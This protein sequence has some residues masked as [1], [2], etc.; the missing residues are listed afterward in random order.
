[1]FIP[2]VIQFWEA[3][4]S[5][6]YFNFDLWRRLAW[7][8]SFPYLTKQMENLPVGMDEFVDILAYSRRFRG[9]VCM[10]CIYIYCSLLIKITANRLYLIYQEASL[11]RIQCKSESFPSFKTDLM[12][13]IYLKS[14]DLHPTKASSIECISL[15]RCV[16]SFRKIV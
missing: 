13:K 6:I 9:D 14:K 8:M 12:L 10:S 7:R 3:P 15:E 1:M 5:I 16:K 4:L 2:F 11:S